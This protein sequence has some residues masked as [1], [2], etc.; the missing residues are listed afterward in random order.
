ML[1]AICVSLSVTLLLTPPAIAQDRDDEI[2]ELYQ[3]LGLPEILAV[4]QEEG[5]SYGEELGQD[6]LPGGADS[7]WR[8]AVAMIYD[9]EMM[10]EEVYGAFA[11]TIRDDDIDAML[12]FFTSDRG[13]RIIAL[14]VDARRAMLDED[15]EEASK[16]AAALQA[17]DETARFAAIRTFV[18][19]NDLIESNVVGAL[20]SSYAFYM[21]LIDGGV[22]P[23]G[24][25]ADTALQD[26]WAQEPDIRANTTEWVY[27]FLMLAY[28]PLSDADI[29][30]YQSFSESEAGAD[31]NDALFQAFDGMFEDIS[32]GLGLAA[33]RFMV[34][35]EL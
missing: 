21:G 34:S 10:N 2:D 16:E 35:Q 12:E 15:I 24:V 20:N 11:E 8:S 30:A 17:A 4:M 7:D 9:L 6:M 29:A 25:T 14:E 33:S 28:Q 18:E 31:L 3:A 22:M 1:R 19:T 13:Q 5:I 26:V 23:P 32:R 27:G